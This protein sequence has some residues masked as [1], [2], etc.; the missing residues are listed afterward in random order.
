MILPLD[1]RSLYHH[2]PVSRF[3]GRPSA[4]GQLLGPEP[5]LDPALEISRVPGF[6]PRP[7]P[8]RPRPA[9]DRR[10]HGRQEGHHARRGARH[11]APRQGDRL[12][13]ARE[14]AA[15]RPAHQGGLRPVRPSFARTPRTS[16]SRAGPLSDP[17]YRATHVSEASFSRASAAPTTTSCARR[18]ASGP[19]RCSSG[20]SARTPPPSVRP[21][22]SLPHA[23]V[24]SA[25]VKLTPSIVA[26]SQTRAWSRSGSSSCSSRWT[27]SSTRDVLRPLDVWAGAP[28]R[29]LCSLRAGWMIRCHVQLKTE[30]QSGAG[31]QGAASAGSEQR[32]RRKGAW[33]S[34]RSAH[35]GRG[36]RRAAPSLVFR[37]V[38]T[39]SA[40]RWEASARRN[41]QCA[42]SAQSS[43]RSASA[44]ERIESCARG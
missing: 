44:A 22:P 23:P 34:V 11:A 37:S 29:R 15:A 27:R 39:I 41:V 18:G 10:H 28:S 36:L 24:T 38:C 2:V 17:P 6:P 19:R 20:F 21:L 16:R 26:L 8:R 4:H 30:T 5:N 1:A 33:A 42:R 43:E 13:A 25:G 3:P 40:R 9:S 35:A 7:S 31:V 14:E 32:N 12:G